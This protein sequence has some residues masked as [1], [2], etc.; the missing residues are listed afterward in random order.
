MTY[1]LVILFGALYP[2]SAGSINALIIPGHYEDLDACNHAGRDME[3]R[4][5]GGDR[6]D[7]VVHLKYVCIQSGAR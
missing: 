4:K 2:N 7:D 3:L 6:S 5:E 1:T